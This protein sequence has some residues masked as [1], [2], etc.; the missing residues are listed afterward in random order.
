LANQSYRAATDIVMQY[1]IFFNCLKVDLIYAENY[2]SVEEARSGIF[3][4]I[5]FFF[6]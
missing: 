6:I 5:K 1:G 2:T 3:E 4:Y